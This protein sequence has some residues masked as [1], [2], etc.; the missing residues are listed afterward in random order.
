MIMNVRRNGPSYY[1][2]EYSP[3]C[4]N[5]FPLEID[6]DSHYSAD[7]AGTGSRMMGFHVA[8]KTWKVR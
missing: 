8:L 5:E 3:L 4:E 7:Y 1:S 6:T 2:A